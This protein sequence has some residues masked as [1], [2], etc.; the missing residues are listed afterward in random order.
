MSICLH[1]YYLKCKVQAH[2]ETKHYVTLHFNVNT[3]KKKNQHRCLEMTKSS[4]HN[5]IPSY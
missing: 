4:K 1:T 5:I 2:A 3:D